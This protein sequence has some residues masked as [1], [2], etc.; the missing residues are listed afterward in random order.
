MAQGKRLRRQ[1][2]RHAAARPGTRARSSRVV[3]DL[4]A[5]VPPDHGQPARCPQ[6]DRFHPGAVVAVIRA[7]CRGR[8]SGRAPGSR[9]RDRAVPANAACGRQQPPGGGTP[10]YALRFL[11]ELHLAGG[12]IDAAGRDLDEAATL[13]A[14]LLALEPD[15]A[16][17]IKASA[18]IALD[19]AEILLA[20]RDPGVGTRL[21]AANAQIKALLARDPRN[22]LWRR[23]LQAPA[24]LLAARVPGNVVAAKQALDKAMQ[25]LERCMRAHHTI[26]ACAAFS[27]RH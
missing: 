9:I 10:A 23:D 5:Q 25:E 3:R 26:A 27:P 13:S 11:A 8:C 12:D 4:A 15:N 7:T 18:H 19:Q 16:G 14:R 22:F 17:W 1:Q 20:R 6:S 21:A 24:L 2:R